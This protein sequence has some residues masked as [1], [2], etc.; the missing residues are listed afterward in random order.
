[1]ATKDPTVALLKKL[2]TIDRL[3]GEALELMKRAFPA[4]RKICWRHGDHWRHATVQEVMGYRADG[5]RLRVTGASGRV[6]DVYV[7]TVMLDL[8]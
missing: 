7:S 8:P 5:A 1:M 2:A 4:G 3:D 6:Y